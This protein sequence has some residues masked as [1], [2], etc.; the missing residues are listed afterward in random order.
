MNDSLLRIMINDEDGNPGVQIVGEITVF[1][2]EVDVSFDVP[3]AHHALTRSEEIALAELVHRGLGGGVSERG[4][5]EASM[6]RR[7]V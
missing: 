2:G 5:T 7:R 3:A 6:P 4:A 1:P